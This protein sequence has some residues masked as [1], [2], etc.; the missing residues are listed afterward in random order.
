M[1]QF[2]SDRRRNRTERPLSGRLDDEWRII[3]RRPALV[4]R[5]RRWQVTDDRFDDLDGLLGLAGHHV[6]ASPAADH[7]L[8]RLVGIARHDELAARV[9]LQRMMPGLLAVVRRRHRADDVDSSF[10]QL[11]GAAWLV[12]QAYQPDARPSRIAANLVR[13][14]SYRAFIAPSRLR[15]ATEV[16]TDPHT[17]DETPAVVVVSSC[18]ELATLLREARAMGLEAT[19]VDFVKSFL[20]SGSSKALAAEREVTT[21][22]IRNHRARTAARLRACA[23][24]A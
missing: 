3:R 20:R 16:V 6:D 9:V 11:I 21:R 19:D 12:I 7:V 17:L 8:G 10:E 24:V 18:E 1:D 14:A 5:A 23:L 13:D 4:E 2:S 15:S 22:T